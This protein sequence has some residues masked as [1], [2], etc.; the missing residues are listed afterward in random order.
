MEI[1]SGNLD[2]FG[3]I[4]V[5]LGGPS[6]E[7][8]VSLASGRAV[9]ESLKSRG[10]DVV[11]VD[12][13]TD[14]W[15]INQRLIREANIDVAFI[16]LHGAFGEDG[17]IQ[18]MLEQMNIPYTG[19]DPAASRLAINKIASRQIFQRAGL[20]V[21]KYI[22]VQSKEDKRLYSEIA[23]VLL[24]PFVVKPATQGSSIGL[25]IVDSPQQL[26]KAVEYATRF[27]KYII[28][29]EYIKG[30][31]ITVA[32]LGDTALPPIEIFPKNKFYDYEAKYK[33]GK[34]D[35]AVPAELTF[36]LSTCVQR[37]AQIAHRLLGCFGFSRVDMRIDTEDTV[38]VLEVNSIPGLT[39]TSLLP[40]AAMATG[41]SF[42]QLCTYILHLAYERLAKR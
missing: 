37:V 36:R 42:T 27:D 32:I 9:Y 39:E 29:E 40:K 5:L 41:I 15:E 22:V 26:S 17:Q 25:S 30:R 28:I 16:A 18:A 33:L 1:D 31:E 12:I 20:N 11:A 2:R 35:Y 10:M 34:S 14:E 21:P 4:G 7:R 23:K 13:Q 24:P 6:S 3:K 8:E 38:F 19:S